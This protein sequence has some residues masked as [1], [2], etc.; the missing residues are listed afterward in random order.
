VKKTGLLIKDVDANTS[1]VNTF[2]ELGMLGKFQLEGPNILTEVFCDVRVTTK[3]VNTDG[4]MKGPPNALLVLRLKLICC[5][6]PGLF[7]YCVEMKMLRV[8]WQVATAKVDRHVTPYEKQAV[9]WNL[10][11]LR[12]SELVEMSK[13]LHTMHWALQAILWCLI[14]G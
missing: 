6:L 2:P 13:K 7:G 3:L 9:N 8:K 12:K 5:T 11:C 14:P 1:V 4:T 10:L